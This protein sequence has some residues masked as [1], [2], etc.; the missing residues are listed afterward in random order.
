MNLTIEFPR[1][2]PV[3]PPPA[4]RWVGFR[5][6]HEVEG[7]RVPEPTNAVPFPPAVIPPYSP[8]VALNMTEAIQWMSYD[9]MRHFCS[10][11][12]PTR[13]RI[14]HRVAI[15][16]NNG[17]ANGFDGGTPHRDYINR[18]DLTAVKLN[19]SPDYPRYDKCQRT[20]E[21]SFITGVRDGN[22]I[23]CAPGI[24]AIDAR[25]FKYPART[26]VNDAP[27]AA[28]KAILDSIIEHGWYSTA[29]C[30]ADPPFH[31]RGQWGSGCVIVYPFILD[32]AVS[33]EAK[34]FEPWDETFLPDPVKVYR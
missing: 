1:A 30:A 19:G 22:V 11:V 20:F 28:Q 32:R 29:V 6:L 14:L 3:P 21:G 18:K 8:T 34:F 9:L 33:Y 12:T 31:F 16:M 27:T 26:N 17:Q 2:A 24:D 4:K 13:W 15:A 5:A 25:S 10:A 23:W 7:G